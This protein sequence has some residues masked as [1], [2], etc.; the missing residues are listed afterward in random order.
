MSQ[1]KRTRLYWKEAL[2]QVNLNPDDEPAAV[3]Q[4]QWASAYQ[5]AQADLKAP[6][7][8]VWLPDEIA[9]IIRQTHP[10]QEPP[11]TQTN[12]HRLTALLLAVLLLVPAAISY[13]LAYRRI[14]SH[15]R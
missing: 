1:P 10:V 5:Q 12:R 6:S 3:H 7:A 15:L 11:S 4:R 9:N 13:W 14:T 2:R 8:I